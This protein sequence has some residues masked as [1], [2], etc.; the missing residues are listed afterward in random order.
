MAVEIPAG[1][2]GGQQQHAER[3]HDD[4]LGFAGGHPSGSHDE[5][6]RRDRAEDDAPQLHAD[7]E[8]FQHGHMVLPDTPGYFVR[9]LL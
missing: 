4:L 3:L 2:V 9:S 6:D 1:H 5:S 8:H 7:V